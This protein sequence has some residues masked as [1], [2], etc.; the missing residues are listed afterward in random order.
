MG[1]GA[2]KL[3]RAGA[4][5]ATATSTDGLLTAMSRTGMLVRMMGAVHATPEATVRRET[6]PGYEGSRGMGDSR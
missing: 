2:P 4:E 5:T 6:S 3:I 1:V